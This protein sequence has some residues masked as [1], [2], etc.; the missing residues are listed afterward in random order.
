VITIFATALSVVLVTQPVRAHESTDVELIAN[1]LRGK[2]ST[3]AFAK[4]FGDRKILVDSKDPLLY[5]DISGVKTPA[6]MKAVNYE[7][8]QARM[9][10]IRSGHRAAPAVLIVR[11]SLEEPAEGDSALEIRNKVKPG[12]RVYYVEVAIGNLAWH[13]LKI[14]V[15]EEDGR[16]KAQVIWAKVS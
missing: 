8:V 1:W 7:F 3:K 4:P 16:A 6:G 2:E 11:S 10:A 5:T 12:G 13:W 15:R 14:V 9:R